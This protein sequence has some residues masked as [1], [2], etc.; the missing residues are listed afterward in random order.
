[1]E[2]QHSQLLESW[3][4][5]G[6]NKP[7]LGHTTSSSIDDRVQPKSSPVVSVPKIQNPPEVLQDD[8]SK[9][10]K[11]RLEGDESINSAWKR[12]LG[13]SSGKMCL[14][15]VVLLLVGHFVGVE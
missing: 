6:L 15:L 14:H 3:T 5:Q 12:L 4:L 7:E 9:V 1:M 2:A 11:G 10:M 8:S 13:R